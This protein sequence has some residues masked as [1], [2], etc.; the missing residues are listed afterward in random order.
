MSKAKQTRSIRVSGRRW[1]VRFNGEAK[2]Y[3]AICHDG[4]QA[5][6][7]QIVFNREVLRSDRLL[8]DSLVHEMLHA[9]GWP[10]D[11]TFVDGFAKDVARELIRFGFKRVKK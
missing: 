8:V 1:P 6:P 10:I 4:L 9:A 5:T 3:F 11:E 7:R 2:G